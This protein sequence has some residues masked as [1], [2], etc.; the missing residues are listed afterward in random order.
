MIR[1]MLKAT[2]AFLI[3]YLTLSRLL[4]SIYPA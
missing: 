3:S 2:R 4:L 1:I